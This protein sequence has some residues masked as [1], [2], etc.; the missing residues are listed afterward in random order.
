MLIAPPGSLPRRLT[1]SLRQRTWSSFVCAQSCYLARIMTNFEKF[2]LA[3]V[4]LW[5]LS[6]VAVK[7]GKAAGVPAG[8]I[9]LAESL[10][11]S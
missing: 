1:V 10:V 3:L 7:W 6:H 4:L 8:V 2:L 11:V 5:A 9:S